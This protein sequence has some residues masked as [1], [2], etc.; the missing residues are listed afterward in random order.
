MQKLKILVIG[1]EKSGKSVIS[2]YLYNPTKDTIQVYRPTVGTR[3]LELERPVD[4]G[5]DGDKMVSI[6]LWDTSG[7]IKYEHIWSLLK[8]D[9]DGIIIVG[10]GDK[11][12][13][14]DEI[15]GWINNFPKKMKIPPN[16]C[17]GLLNHPSGKI[18]SND[19]INI[20]NVNFTD[21]SFET[22]GSTIGPLFEGFLQKL[23]KTKDNSSV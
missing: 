19:G 7:H 8:E 15:E 9:V 23:L 4:T 6:Q 18:Q 10:N 11:L 16:K 12:N 22:K 21:T 17:L 20:L 2:N 14:K 13:Q 5:E 3:I 1:P